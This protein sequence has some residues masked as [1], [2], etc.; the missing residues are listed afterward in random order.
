MCLPSELAQ[1]WLGP[2]GASA[3]TEADAASLLAQQEAAAEAGAAPEDT[4]HEAAETAAIA[5]A[6]DG[7][8]VNFLLCY[9]AFQASGCC[10]LC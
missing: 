4:A 10:W 7:A 8:A 2:V 9:K 1:L 6:A 5:A 3:A